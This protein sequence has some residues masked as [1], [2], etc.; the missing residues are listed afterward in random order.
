V[1]DSPHVQKGGEGVRPGLPSLPQGWD[2][3]LERAAARLRTARFGVIAEVQLGEVGFGP[4]GG[5]LD[6]GSSG[7]SHMNVSR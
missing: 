4:V 1:L 2:G 7:L 6:A 5:E 3:R